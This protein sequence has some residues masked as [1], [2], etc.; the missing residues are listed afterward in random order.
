V[1]YRSASGLSRSLCGDCI[2]L[3]IFYWSRTAATVC[4]GRAQ[5]DEESRLACIE[6]SVTFI[7]ITVRPNIARPVGGAPIAFREC[8]ALIIG[9]SHR[10]CLRLR[11]RSAIGSAPMFGNVL[12]IGAHRGPM[13]LDAL[14]DNL[15]ERRIR[16]AACV[17][18]TA[19]FL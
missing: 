18:N 4:F 10:A 19:Q 2:A 7:A 1:A 8:G 15:P 11:R 6:D 9:E 12:L 14:L 3:D 5:P 16:A 13:V 17:Q